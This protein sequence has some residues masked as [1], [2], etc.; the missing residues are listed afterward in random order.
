MSRSA[1]CTEPPGSW[2]GTSALL[3][4]EAAQTKHLKQ[5]DKKILKLIDTPDGKE[6]AFSWT[7]PRCKFHQDDSIHPVHGPFLALTCVKC[8]GYIEDTELSEDDAGTF[9][10]VVGYSSALLDTED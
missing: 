8:E 7:C 9:A 1:W 5:E 3:G 2:G 6:V 4:G 10:D